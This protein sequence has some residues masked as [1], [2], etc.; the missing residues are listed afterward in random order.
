MRRHPLVFLAVF[1][2]VSL[3]AMVCGA[4][5][6]LPEASA[7][8]SPAMPWWGWPL[9][10]FLLTFA[11]GVVA[12]LAGVGGGVLF[13]PIVSG[14]FPF[15]LDFVR[16]CGL[17]AAL[18]GA[19]S[20]GPRLLNAKMASLRLAMP[21]ALIASA[22]SIVGAL[23]GLALPANVVQAALGGSILAI[24]VLMMTAK[25]S[26]RP[27]VRKPDWFAELFHIHGIYTEGS[28]GQE[29]NWQVHRT[30]QALVLFVFIGI[31]AGMFGLG[32]GWANVPV[33]NLV[34]GAPLKVSVATSGFLVAIT[35][36]AAAWVYIGRGC[37]IPLLVVPCVVGV[38]LGSKIGARLLRVAKPGFVR[39]LVI[40]VLVFAGLKSLTKGLGLPFIL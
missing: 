22:S 40:G 10:L 9:A 14:F 25:R 37:V 3:V 39:W 11:M 30:P 13:V 2:V 33:L 8:A 26:E 17:L 29:I 16:A 34:M 31:L 7:A 18:S 21:I 32:A 24:C 36:T 4:Q 5:E 38:M 6:A 15:H 12:P 27:E 28:T 35:D 23:L 20:A 19:L 1:T